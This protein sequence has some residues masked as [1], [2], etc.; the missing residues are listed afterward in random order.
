[1]PQNLNLFRQVTKIFDA[2][3]YSAG[4]AKNAL[5]YAAGLSQIAGQPKIDIFGDNAKSYPGETVIPYTHWLNIRGN[6][7]RWQFIDKYNA[8]P[9]KIQNR[10]M[11]I[12]NEM[13]TL[14]D[15]E[16]YQHQKTTGQEF[17]AMLTRY[18][19]GKGRMEDR[20]LTVS[21]RSQSMHKMAIQKMWTAAQAKS[22]LKNMN[23]WRNN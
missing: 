21:G 3:S 13:R 6:D 15:D 16:L 19:A 11:R 20:I 22:K 10:P 7:S 17:S 4:D 2:T 23:T 1:M 8:Y 9:G 12:G 5:L 14:T 18:I